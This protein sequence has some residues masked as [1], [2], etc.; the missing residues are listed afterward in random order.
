MGGLYSLCLVVLQDG[1]LILL[2]FYSSF[3]WLVCSVV[4]R[5]GWPRLA[6]VLQY[7]GMA[8]LCS[9]AAC[10]GWL[11]F[12]RIAVYAVFKRFRATNNS[13]LLLPERSGCD[14]G[15]WGPARWTYV[16]SSPHCK[17]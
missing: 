9:V 16:A 4:L 17:R 5:D 11:V 3:N 6:C 13:V 2:Y 10:P 1:W 7:F 15:S 14:T 12:S 8:G